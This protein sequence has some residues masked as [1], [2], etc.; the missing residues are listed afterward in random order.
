MDVPQTPQLW[1]M[2]DGAYHLPSILLLPVPWLIHG[3]ISH[4]INQMRKTVASCTTSSSSP[5]AP[6]HQSPDPETFAS[7]E[8][9]KVSLLSMPMSSAL[10]V[11]ERVNAGEHLALRHRP[12]GTSCASTVSVCKLR[13]NTPHC[14]AICCLL[15]LVIFYNQNSYRLMDITL[16]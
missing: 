16:Y 1:N 15:A 10:H 8:I 11:H 6:P 7:H 12:G 5:L 9:P 14:V 2:R 3:V 13:A 4:P